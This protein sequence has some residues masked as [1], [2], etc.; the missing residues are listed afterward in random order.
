MNSYD[1]IIKNGIIIDGTRAPRYQA[2]LGIS[3]GK[4]ARIGDLSTARADRVTDASGLIVSPGF[5]DVHAHSDAWLLKYP[6]FFPKVSQ[7][8]TTEFLMLDGI[9]YAPVNQQTN[10]DWVTYLRALNGLWLREY[11]GWQ[12]IADYMELLERKNCQN[13]A[14][15]IPYG[16]VR[17]LACGFNRQPVDDFQLKEIRSLVAQGME[18]GALGISTGFDYLSQCFASTTELVAACQEMV[19]QNGVYVSH[20]RYQAGIL[21]GLKEAVEI[22]RKA[23]VPVHISHLKG[24][25]E[26]EAEAILNYLSTTAIHEVDFS[27]DVYPYSASS[28]MLSTLLPH[29]VWT[30][31]SLAALHELKK[32]RVQDLFARR[33]ARSPLD[34]IKIAW[35]ASQSGQNLVGKTLEEYI[36]TSGRSEAEAL[37]EL[38]ID[39]GLAVLLIFLQG[40]DA[41]V[42]PFLAHPASMIG[43]DGIYQEDGLI[44]PRLFGTAARILG[45]CVRDLHLFTLEEAVYK[46]SGHPAKRFGLAK[47]GMIQEG[48]WADLVSFDASTIQDCATFDDPRQFPT[49]IGNVWVNGIP[50]WDH[51]RTNQ[52]DRPPLPGRFLR[53]GR[54]TELS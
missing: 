35:T 18:E 51:G 8:F 53:G 15:F 50:I 43:S 47:R 28:T 2:D 12:S 27:F 45:R 7:G 14:A 22:G 23:Q 26:S 25:T 34:R 19:K 39:E 6:C 4:I 13:T 52:N 32:P 29:E 1:H 40:E 31:G 49:G 11:R 3:W 30:E 10:A 38:L 46:L 5:I 33:L 36:T 54:L 41:L 16:N 37:T 21:E 24:S 42:S 20:I 17:S 9:S 44:H 48:H